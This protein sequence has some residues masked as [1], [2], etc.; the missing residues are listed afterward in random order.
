LRATEFWY[1]ACV[2]KFGGGVARLSGAPRHANA[3]SIIKTKAEQ[4]G[5]EIFECVTGQVILIS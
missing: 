2:N 1:C 5:Q 3:S 4:N